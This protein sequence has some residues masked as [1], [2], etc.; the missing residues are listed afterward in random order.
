MGAGD[1]NMKKSWHPRLQK[2]QE[3]VWLHEQEALAE[4]K[5]LEEL[6][7]ERD[8]ERQMQELQRIHEAAGGK[9]RSERVEWMYA[10]PAANS[11]PSEGEL[12]DYLLGRKRVDKLLQGNET[13]QLSRTATLGAQ[14]SGGANTARDLSAKMREDP[15]VAIKQQEQAMYDMLIKDPTRLKQLRE[16]MGMPGRSEERRH[17]HSGRRDHGRHRHRDERHRAQHHR[18]DRH[19]DHRHRRHED[20]RRHMGHSERN[21]SHRGRIHDWDSRS[22]CR[23]HRSL[24]PRR[25]GPRDSR[26]RDTDKR[27]ERTP[28]VMRAPIDEAEREAKLAAMMS[29]AQTM[30]Q[31]RS[32]WVDTISAEELRERAVDEQQRDATHDTSRWKEGGGTG[33]ASFLLDQQRNLWGEQSG[34]MNLHERLRRG[35]H[36]LQRVSDD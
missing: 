35:R 16:R 10:T 17:S 14:D 15:L 5:K 21:A 3:K 23:D 29:D 22:L 9:R 8:Q 26:P 1:L 6:R 30:S 19:H 2:N 24:S 33:K 12:E 27:S 28:R 31:R 13:E 18:E 20:E 4:R 11:G 34:G 36:A 25:P 32:A 7:K